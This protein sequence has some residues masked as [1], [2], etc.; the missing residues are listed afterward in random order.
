[1]LAWWLTFKRVLTIGI[2]KTSC[3]HRIFCEATKIF[4]KSR[5]KNRNHIYISNVIGE[6]SSVTFLEFDGQFFFHFFGSLRNSGIHT[7]IPLWR[8]HSC[9]ETV[10][11]S[12]HM[13]GKLTCG[14]D[15]TWQKHVSLLRISKFYHILL[16]LLLPAAEELQTGS[17]VKFSEFLQFVVDEGRYGLISK[18]WMSIH[19]M[20]HPCLVKYNYIAKM[21][22][23]NLE[24]T[25]TITDSKSSDLFQKYYSSIPS[26]ILDGIRELYALDFELFGYDRNE[27]WTFETFV[28]D[29]LAQESTVVL[30]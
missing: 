30:L 15:N 21:E 13:W 5:N 1:M 10:Q 25:D 8:G 7:W 29:Y 4:N 17:G 22:T 26:K 23:I 9:V 6:T 28:Y 16:T 24:F 12:I 14:G 19:N 20:C 27:V 3:W 18:D 11:R 2:N